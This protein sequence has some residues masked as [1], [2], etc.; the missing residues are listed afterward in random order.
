M[1]QRYFPYN[2][3]VLLASCALYSGDTIQNRKE[4]FYLEKFYHGED[5]MMLTHASKSFNAKQKSQTTSWKME[6]LVT[7][8]S[9]PKVFR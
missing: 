4:V 5:L 3:F 6:E 2:I 9:L 8:A 1:V 7:F